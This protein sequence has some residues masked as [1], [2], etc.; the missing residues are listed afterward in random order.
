M[1]RTG[2]KTL[3][4]TTR[5]L[6]FN[7]DVLTFSEKVFRKWRKSEG[8]DK[9]GLLVLVTT[10]KEGALIGG[11]SFVE[12]L[13]DDVID[14]VQGDNIPIFAEQEKFN[15]AVLSSINRVVAVL[16]GKE[17]PGAPQ[18]IDNTRKRTYKTKEETDRVKPVTGTIVL[19]LLLIAFV[20]PMLQYYGYVSKD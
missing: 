11:E 9:I 18:R 4:V 3:V 13:G 6:E 5:K 15:E 16:E 20:V 1:E 8:G 2:Y 10:T 17:D 14:S 12:A 19:T 7:P